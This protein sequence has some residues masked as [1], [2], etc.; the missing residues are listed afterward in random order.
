M[1]LLPLLALSSPPQAIAV[2]ERRL[3]ALAD[4][5][6]VVFAAEQELQARV[7]AVAAPD[8]SR[9]FVPHHARRSFACYPR[10]WGEPLA[11]TLALQATHD[12]ICSHLQHCKDAA[13]ALALN[14]R[15]P[16]VTLHGSSEDCEALAG[17]HRGT[18]CLA[19]CLHGLLAFLNVYFGHRYSCDRR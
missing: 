15:L 9:V 3:A 7:Y 1:T 8:G 16:E 18:C 6:D 4:A 11:T 10:L 19:S 13:A 12:V 2:E 14:S 5:A 17:R